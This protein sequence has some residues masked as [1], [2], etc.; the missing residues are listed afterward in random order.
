MYKSIKRTPRLDPWG[1]Y[2]DGIENINKKNFDVAISNFDKLIIKFNPDGII[3]SPNGCPCAACFARNKLSKLSK[4]QR[5]WLIKAFG[6]RAVCYGYKK[7]Y[8]KAVN[9][10]ESVLNID[11]KNIKSLHN[12]AHIKLLTSDFHAAIKYLTKIITIDP[13]H[14]KSYLKR[15]LA[16]REIDENEK[17]LKDFEYHGYLIKK[18][19]DNF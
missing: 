9:D 10:F 5:Y 6:N 8:E 15:A 14:N 16:Y 18:D 12:I 17:A 3:F 7:K 1:L 4:I 19:K 2:Y 11:N 13:E